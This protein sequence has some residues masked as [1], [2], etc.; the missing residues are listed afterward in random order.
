MKDDD[1]VLRIKNESATCQAEDGR[2][3]MFVWQ[4]F[5]L[6][7]LLSA[8]SDANIIRTAGSGSAL[9]NAV[10]LSRR[11]PHRDDSQAHIEHPEQAEAFFSAD[12]SDVVRSPHS[13][14]WGPQGQ[15]PETSGAYEGETSDCAL[16]R[17]MISRSS[18]RRFPWCASR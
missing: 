7:A 14:R 6:E 5:R 9:C 1:A 16:T 10:V 3:S 8:V 11:G 12:E 18:W 17:L 15:H 4:T 2:R 13:R